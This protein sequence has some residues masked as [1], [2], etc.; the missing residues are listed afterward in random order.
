[1]QTCVTWLVHHPYLLSDKECLSTVVEVAELGVSGSKSQH[2]ATDVPIMKEDK[3]LSPASRR[4]RD[5]AEHLLS[6][7]MEQVGGASH[8][9]ILTRSVVLQVGYFPSACGAESLTT[10]LDEVSLVQQC[11]SWNGED[12]STR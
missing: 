2:R 12:L 6:V 11:N 5:A 9:T 10:L 8:G 4:V 1:M 3:A 7:V